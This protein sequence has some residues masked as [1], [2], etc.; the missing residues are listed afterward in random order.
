[1][2]YIFNNET[3]TFNGS[4]SVGDSECVVVTLSALSDDKVEGT[5]DISMY[6]QPEVNAVSVF[7]IDNDCKFSLVKYY[8]CLLV[9]CTMSDFRVGFQ[10]AS[11]S[12]SESASALEIAIGV[13]ADEDDITPTIAVPLGV[14]ITSRD[15]SA[16]G[17]N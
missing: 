1:M 11:Y 13:L 9:I 3:I 5:E 8:H 14:R 17:R 6:F 15:D 12:V 16:V 10:Q 2:D 4:Y 7:I